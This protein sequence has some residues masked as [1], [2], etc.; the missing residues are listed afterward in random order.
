MLQ[1]AIDIYYNCLYFSSTIWSDW[2]VTYNL[3]FTF[4]FTYWLQ[5]S[6]QLPTRQLILPNDVLI[7]EA[8]YNN[9]HD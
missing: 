4:L 7:I 6:N 5:R 2:K 9:Y 3:L 8:R 1:V